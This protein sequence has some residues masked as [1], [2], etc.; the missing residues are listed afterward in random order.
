M[1]EFKSKMLPETDAR[2]QV[3]KSVVGHLS[4]S[5]KDVPQVSALDWVIHVVDEP[6]VNAF[7]LPV[8]WTQVEKLLVILKEHFI[9]LP[10]T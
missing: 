1:E 7:V 4:E 8:S 5:N 9:Y 2:Y 10:S 6:G 3:V